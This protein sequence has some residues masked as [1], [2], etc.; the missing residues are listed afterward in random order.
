MLLN[1]IKIDLKLGNDDDHD[2]VA[3][4]KQYALKV[5]NIYKQLIRFMVSKD[6]LHLKKKKIKKKK[7]KQTN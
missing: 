7:I 2:N 1:L 6:N 4:N 5:I 3:Q